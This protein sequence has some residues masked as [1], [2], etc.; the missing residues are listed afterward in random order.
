M[1]DPAP[2]TLL[3]VLATKLNVESRFWAP[4]VGLTARLVQ[5]DTD[6]LWTVAIEEPAT[7]GW[8]SSLSGN[9]ILDAEPPVV[10]PPADPTQQIE[11]WTKVDLPARYNPVPAAKPVRFQ[12]IGLP[13]AVPLPRLG[14]WKRI[15]LRLL[16]D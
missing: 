2:G 11:V 13:P 12:I 4:Y 6:G 3:R 5:V 16:R 9:I 15:L 7:T 10:P 8:L 1:I 14:L